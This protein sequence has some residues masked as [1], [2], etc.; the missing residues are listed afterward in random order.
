MFR[1]ADPHRRLSSGKRSLRISEVTGRMGEGGLIDPGALPLAPSFR[2]VRA[3]PDS[4]SG[5]TTWCSARPIAGGVARLR[6][7]TRKGGAHSGPG[8]SPFFVGHLPCKR[9]PPWG[10]ASSRIAV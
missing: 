2:P 5:G 4:F 8:V 9:E 7:S 1:K 3:F 10:P 6:D